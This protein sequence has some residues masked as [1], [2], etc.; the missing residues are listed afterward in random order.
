MVWHQRRIAIP[1]DPVPESVTD[2]DQRAWA[3]LLL[4][5]WQ[6]RFNRLIILAHRFE[7]REKFTAGRC[8]LP[9][10]VVPQHIAG[11][12]DI[13]GRDAPGQGGASGP[14]ALAEPRI[15]TDP[16]QVSLRRPLDRSDPA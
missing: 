15:R 2:D 8:D 9:S 13:D 10:L 3:K 4:R 1:A 11:A 12:K 16:T 6:I 5:R 14:A 7:R